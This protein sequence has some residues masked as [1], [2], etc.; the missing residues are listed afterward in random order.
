MLAAV[1]SVSIAW[2]DHLH[3]VGEW[4]HGL[5]DGADNDSVLH[6]FL[7][8]VPNHKHT[9][10]FDL[11]RAGL[12]RALVMKQCK[13]MTHC[14]RDWDATGNSECKFFMF[15]LSSGSHPLNY[16]QHTHHNYCP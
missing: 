5:G 8:S 14:H 4:A 9:M 11:G 10:E 15:A 6:P 3:T 16:H 7:D 2:A 1:F 12:N 13:K